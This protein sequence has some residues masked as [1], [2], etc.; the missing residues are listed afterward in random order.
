MKKQLIASILRSIAFGILFLLIYFL[1]VNV[2]FLITDVP[3]EPRLVLLYVGFG[4]ALAYIIT[5]IIEKVK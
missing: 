2:I 4:G 5:T 3:E 1:L